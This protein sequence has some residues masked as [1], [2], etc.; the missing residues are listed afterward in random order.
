VFT[1]RSLSKCF[2]VPLVIER[3]AARWTARAGRT[4]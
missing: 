4:R 1:E 2:G 3:H